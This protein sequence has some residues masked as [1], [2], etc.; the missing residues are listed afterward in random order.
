MQ[1]FVFCEDENESRQFASKKDLVDFVSKE[2]PNCIL[3]IIYGK[4]VSFEKKITFKLGPAVENKM[5]EKAKGR[6][7]QSRGQRIN[8]KVKMLDNLKSQEVEIRAELNKIYAEND[9]NKQGDV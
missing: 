9:D 6:E 2:E 5:P 1:Y 3:E 8:E 7:Q 4:R